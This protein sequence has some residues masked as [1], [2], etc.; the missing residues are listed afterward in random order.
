MEKLNK[1]K[2][3]SE[4][5]PR[6]RQKT[7]LSLHNDHKVCDLAN[8][9]DFIYMKLNSFIRVFKS[10]CFVVV[11]GALQHTELSNKTCISLQFF[12]FRTHQ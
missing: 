7:K 11:L 5:I 12:I 6:F 9:Q 10:F 2:D 4:I 8:A 3:I 1:T